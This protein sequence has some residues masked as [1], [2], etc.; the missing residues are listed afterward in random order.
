[1]VARG[2]FNGFSPQAIQFFAD[3]SANNN[4]AWFDEH[5]EAYERFALEPARLFIEEMGSLLRTLS[6]G[7]IADPRVNKSIFR[8]N[9]DTRF[10]KNKSPYKN[11]LGVWFWEGTG[12]RME[13]PGFY[14][15]LAADGILL[16]AGLH[17]FP[18][19]ILQAYR[20]AVVHPELGPALAAAVGEVRKEGFHIGVVTYK[21]TPRGYDPEHE[22]AEYLRYG[23][24]AAYFD[25]GFPDEL[26]SVRLLDYVFSRYEKMSPLFKWL[27]DVKKTMNG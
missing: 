23:G 2:E 17:D 13:C 10:S 20:D 25:A 22:N 14:F 27:L 3:L 18:K 16:A 21:K 19:P 9:R 7:I 24:L 5:K 8:I 15:Q 26:N 1:M 12:G 11:H 6:P 4:K